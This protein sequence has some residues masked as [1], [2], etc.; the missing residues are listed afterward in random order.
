MKE[1]RQ[2][3][4]HR[5]GVNSEPV[6]AQKAPTLR[7]SHNWLLPATSA[8]CSSYPAKP[9]CTSP[10]TSQT[11]LPE[12]HSFRP[13]EPFL[14]YCSPE[15]EAAYINSLEIQ[16][17]VSHDLIELGKVQALSKCVTREKLRPRVRVF[18]D[19]VHVLGFVRLQEKAHSERVRVSQRNGVL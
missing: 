5:K 1:M 9:H 16:E 7:H 13:P 3:L 17:Q 10:R 6:N 18:G 19:C 11:Y 4:K 15:Q 2:R 8:K 12:P 14:G